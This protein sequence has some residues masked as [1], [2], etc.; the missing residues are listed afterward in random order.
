MGSLDYFEKVKH[1]GNKAE[2]L[3][4]K[5]QEATKGLDA[6]VAFEALEGGRVFDTSDR[7]RY[8]ELMAKRGQAKGK[9]QA[10]QAKPASTSDGNVQNAD[11]STGQSQSVKQDNDINTNINGDNNTVNNSQDNSVRQYGGSSR[12]FNYNGGGKGG[13]D[14]PA[15]AATMAGFYDV[16]DSASANASRLDRQIDQNTS[17][18]KRLRANAPES[19]IDP[20][21]LDQRIHEREQY[22]RS[23]ATV[24]AGN[25]FGDMFS[26]KPPEWNSAKPAEEVEA[27]DFEQMY[28]KYTKF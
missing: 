20:Q 2:N 17:T 1:K 19:F 12:T 8:D 7:A 6:E 28:N 22:S 4:S 15:S 21:K 16:D 23:K 3:Q 27:P 25:I 14:S 13:P 11:T 24:M 18:Q 9:A 5:Y 10:Q 26:M